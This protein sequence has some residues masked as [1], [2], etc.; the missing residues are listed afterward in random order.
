MRA[1]RWILEIIQVT[2]KLLFT[3]LQRVRDKGAR[4]NGKMGKWAN[5]PMGSIRINRLVVPSHMI[6][7]AKPLQSFSVK[8]LRRSKKVNIN[9]MMK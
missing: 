6:K 8:R 5:E 4:A 3:S 9:R 2:T 1:H 7:E